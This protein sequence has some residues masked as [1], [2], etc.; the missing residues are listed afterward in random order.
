M[1][2]WPGLGRA[3][4]DAITQY[5]YPVVMGGVLIMATVFVFV[6]LLVDLTYGFIDPRVRYG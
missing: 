3:M 1:F 2:S 5:D 4:V 6:N